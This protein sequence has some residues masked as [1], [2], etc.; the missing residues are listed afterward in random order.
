MRRLRSSLSYANV[1]SSLALFL[2]VSG[3]T[4]IAAA[5][6][7]TADIQQSAVTNG[8]IARNAVTA[9]KINNGAISGTDLKDESVTG[10]DLRNG[11]V[12]G[13]DIADGAIG[14]SKLAPGTIPDPAPGGGPAAQG[15]VS[16]AG[17][18]VRGAGVAAVTSP[19]AGVYT[20]TYTRDVN[21][22]TPVTSIGGAVA[23]TDPDGRVGP[24]T[25]TVSPSGASNATL[26]FETRNPGGDPAPRAFSFL[27]QC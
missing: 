6:I 22:C 21:T 14:A 1:A 10:A 26:V 5:T 20:V 19:S 13:Q 25:V 18:L 24:G 17:A 27:V 9:S 8:K 4:A 7:G 12:E 2:A 11:T 15:V 3:G 23:P 16:A